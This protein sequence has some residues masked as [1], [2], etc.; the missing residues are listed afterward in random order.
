MGR[1]KLYYSPWSGGDRPAQV[2]RLLECAYRMQYGG[3]LPAIQ[4]TAMGKPFFPD[5]PQI[6]FSLSHTKTHVACALGG[7]PVGVDIEVLRSPSPRLIRRVCA[8]AERETFGFMQL[9]VLKESYIKY[10]GNNRV[11]LQELVFRGTP[12]RIVAPDGLALCRLYDSVPGCAA[13]LC[14]G[15]MPPEE[16]IR[17][18][19]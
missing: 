4:K 19:F 18:D 11:S 5:R 10:T 12:D 6:F 13:A 2:R 8:P 17:L 7:A 14:A 3:P 15:E 9:W 16:W 1:I